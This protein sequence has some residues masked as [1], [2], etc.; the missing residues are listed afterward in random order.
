MKAIK[1]LL[2][3]LAIT[4]Y[5]TEAM[6]QSDNKA[7][8]EQVNKIIK[9][10]AADTED[11]LKPIF[12]EYKK[13]AEVLTAIGRAY[14]DVKDTANA[15]K[16]AELALKRDSKFGNAYVLLGD[17]EVAKD[18]GGAAS[19]WFEQATYFDPKNPEGYRRYAQVNSKVS[20]SASVAKL[21][22]LRIQRPDYPVDIISAEIY[23]K[24]GN[25]EKA[26]EYYDKVDRNKMEDHQIASY[27]TDAFLLGKYE[28]SYEI[29]VEG[30]KKFPTYAGLNRVALYDA[31]QLKKYEEALSYAD[32]LFNKSEKAKI[33][34][35]DYLSYG[36]AHLGLKNYD[37]AIA[38]FAKVLEMSN[39][40]DN[41]NSALQKISN[42][43]SDKGDFVK[44][45]EYYQK[46]IDAI[47]EKV[48]AYD[49]AGLAT[50]YSKEASV[51]KDA[52]QTAAYNKAYDVYGQIAEKFTDAK[53]FALNMR[54]QIHANMDP[55]TKT[56]LAKPD[57]EALIAMLE[58]QTDNS[59]AEKKRLA[60]AYAYL[61]YYSLVKNDKAASKDYCTKAIAQDPDNGQAKQILEVL[62]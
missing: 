12:K 59:D 42:A 36:Q 9:S 54:A 60:M 4:G 56:F 41:K 8:I 31:V 14:L 20:P 52:E 27:A 45:A 33:I 57:Y 29:A 39:N 3:G 49:L 40:D 25:M 53:S 55:E 44:A 61:G 28:K 19:T 10:K 23:D 18:N 58:G 30:V 37:E 2:L 17:I 6:A 24:A 48:T 62:K 13:N 26:L 35:N 22:E 34:E 32:A 11:Q 50:I 38:Q 47:G 5:T 7:V 1:Y 51:L 21:E 43:Y 16:Y 15:Q 46:Y